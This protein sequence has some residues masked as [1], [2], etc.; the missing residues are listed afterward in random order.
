M[1]DKKSQLNT[2]K[3]QQAAIIREEK[4][5]R[6]N[7]LEYEMLA[8][9][10]ERKAKLNRLDEIEKQF[11]AFKA[12]K[13]TSFSKLSETQKNQKVYL[14]QLKQM[15]MKAKDLLIKEPFLFPVYEDNS[16]NQENLKKLEKSVPVK[17]PVLVPHSEL[18]KS[19]RIQPPSIPRVF[20][21][22][23]IYNVYLTAD[24]VPA[25]NPL[26]K[27]EV[28]MNRD[29]MGKKSIWKG[30]IHYN[31]EK[32]WKSISPK[33]KKQED[34]ELSKPESINLRQMTPQMKAE[35]YNYRDYSFSEINHSAN[36]DWVIKRMQKYAKFIQN[37]FKPR[38]SEKKQIELEMMIEKVRKYRNVGT[39]KIKL[40]L[41]NDN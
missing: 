39:E 13:N 36:R 40:K 10:A 22:G 23:D 14:D 19:Q 9:E 18:Q 2:L 17:I 31:D 27:A 3:K 26:V 12:T 8:I 34:L 33:K 24:N 20:K 35:R 15:Q 11:Q 25:Y 32:R 21:N 29:E 6:K 37:D 1:L 28:S 4:Q 7:Q 38:I 30:E 41:R 16:L 5:Q